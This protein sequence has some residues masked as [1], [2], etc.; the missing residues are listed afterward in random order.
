MEE[1]RLLN[2]EP[3]SDYNR[4]M[5]SE[6]EEYYN[7]N[8]VNFSS[9]Y[10]AFDKQFEWREPTTPRKIFFDILNQ[11]PLK[12]ENVFLDCGSGLGHVVYLASFFFKKIYG[13]EYIEEIARLS[14]KN[15]QNIMPNGIDYTIF[16]CDMQNL[17]MSI[18]NEAH[19]FYISSPYN[20][21]EL[22]EKFILKIKESI[23]QR[24]RESWII[25]FYPYYENI[26][27][28]YKDVFPLEKT[29]QTIGKVNYYHHV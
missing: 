2:I 24:Q 5:L 18:L 26:M 7:N 16:C 9:S 19:I 27:D 17:D 22:F 13:V 3:D 10:F 6:K 15:L 21:S 11:I 14:E 28:K 23:Y 29:F 20:D 12:S 1:S 25:Y 8:N 4:L